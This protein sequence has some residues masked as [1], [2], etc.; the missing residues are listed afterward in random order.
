MLKHPLLKLGVVF[1]LQAAIAAAGFDSVARAEGDCRGRQS[2]KANRCC[3]ATKGCC[4]SRGANTQV[5]HCDHGNQPVPTVPVTPRGHEDQFKLAPSALGAAD[6]IALVAC[7]HLRADDCRH[8]WT[9]AE[10]SIQPLLCNWR[11]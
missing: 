2:A 11:I 6:A 10:Q 7:H 4:C 5:C 9:S 1:F 3:G 8:D